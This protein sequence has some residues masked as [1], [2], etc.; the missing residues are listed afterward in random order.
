M[1][2]SFTLP[3]V[4][5]CIAAA[6]ASG[7]SAAQSAD[8]WKWQASLYGYLPDISGST[9]F[10]PGSGGSSNTVDADKVLDSLKFAFMGSLQAH[11]GRWGVYSDV[12]YL[13]LGA[14]KSGYRDLS[15]GGAGVPVGANAVVSY[16]LKGWA[17]TVAGLW[18]LASDPS[19]THDVVMGARLFDMRQTF[20]YEVT[21]N[22]GSIAQ[23][24]REGR[25]QAKISNWDAIVGMKGR[26]AFGD[27]RQWFAP[28]YVDIGTGESDLTFQAIGGIGYSFRWGDVVGAWR[29]VDYNMKSGKKVEG[30]TFNGPAIAVVFHW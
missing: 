22:V 30:M 4:A 18:R 13:D 20:G 27:R 2:R 6:F 17:W 26:F 1:T 8:S 21:G 25:S 3:A 28:Y 14:T 24:E 12:V 16:D 23:A 19:S 5:F 9:T 7:E 10:P 29:Y 15:L 11:N